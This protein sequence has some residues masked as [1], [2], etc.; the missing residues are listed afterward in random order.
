V[1]GVGKLSTSHFG[2]VLGQ[3]VDRDLRNV[4]VAFG[5]LRLE[6]VE[7]P[8]KIENQQQLAGP[9]PMP[10]VK[11]STAASTA[12]ATGECR[13]PPA[14]DPGRPSVLCATRAKPGLL[15]FLEE[16]RPSLYPAALVIEIGKLDDSSPGMS[17]RERLHDGGRH[18]AIATADVVKLADRRRK[19]RHQRRIE[20][21][22]ERAVVVD[23]RPVIGVEVCGDRDDCRRLRHL[24]DHQPGESS[25]S[26]VAD[27][28]D[29]TKWMQHEKTPQRGNHAG[30]DL[31]RVTLV[32][33]K[34]RRAKGIGL[35]LFRCSEVAWSA[36][37]KAWTRILCH[38]LERKGHAR[39]GVG[40]RVRKIEPGR[41]VVFDVDV[42]GVGTLE[43]SGHIRDV[44]KF[45]ALQ[46]GRCKSQGAGA[47]IE[48]IGG[49]GAGGECR[50]QDNPAS[51]QSKAA[52][53]RNN[54]STGDAARTARIRAMKTAP[55]RRVVER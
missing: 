2:G 26:A 53:A 10:N 36:Q 5:E 20:R 22:G 49:R 44:M 9:A 55:P 51:R 29:A 45:R 25:A 14:A 19:R 38:Q 54:R 12:W 13:V 40:R 50:N 1:L 7:Y 24:R 16:V 27:Q 39:S 37:K 17:T 8:Q 21:A 48:A 23:A 52:G 28:H 33:P 34:E 11:M 35:G 43:G 4:R 41:A 3:R 47:T 46:T 31:G 6:L 30:D 42:Q 18:V 32:R 15:H